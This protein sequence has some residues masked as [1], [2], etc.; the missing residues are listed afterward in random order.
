MN[1]RDLLKYTAASA[2]ASLAPATVRAATA[3]AGDITQYG[4]FELALPGPAEGNPFLDVTFGAT[5]TLQHRAVTV[6]GFYD[7]D[8]VYKVRF[9]PD[10]QGTWSYA[11]VSNA[12][13]LAGHT[14]SF[15]CAPPAPGTHGPVSVR[16]LQHFAHADGTQ[17]F[18]FGTTCYAWA[19]QPEEMQQQTLATLATAPFN[20]LRMCV[21]PKSYEFNH[22]EPPLYPFPRT[23]P[24]AAHPQGTNDLT[25]FNPAYFAHL[26]RLLAALR[27]RNIQA[28]IILF[29]P[30][31]RWGYATMPAEADDRYLRYVIARF[32][33][34]DNV[35][36]SLANEY[37]FMR[38]KTTQDFERLLRITQ[39]ED[40]YQHLRSIH[41]GHVMFNYGSSLVT[42][43]SL[44]VTDFASA[45]GW[46]QQWR[47][48]VIYDEC[49][50]EGH[51]PRR[52]G[53][54]SAQEMTR[55]FWLGV[56]A[57]CYVTHGETY[58]DPDLP[59]DEAGT[60]R[61]W[62][63]NGG[64]LRGQSPARIAF[65][66]SL[67]ES[68]A[69]HGLIGTP[70][71]YY[72]TAT[73]LAASGTD[74]KAPPA[75]ILHFFDEHQPIVHTFTLPAGAIYRAELIDPWE[76]TITPIPGQH[77]GKATL[78]LPARP[79]QALRFTQIKA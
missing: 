24:D 5:F 30:Y 58:F 47:K 35:W 59:F 57:G 16:G 73:A 39:Q 12:A 31:D 20:K 11:T 55:R 76:R 19:H 46:V 49:Q 44:Q 43:A 10:T 78:T 33:A 17:F 32:A 18:P 64:V 38:A 62:W 67:L 14:G 71:A 6:N 3:P 65:L 68:T 75:A 9:M 1:R 50:Y 63:A 54:I 74:P 21:F 26:E 28:D 77:T 40:P 25:R 60:Q 66:R 51:I 72:L 70:D 2:A 37:D 45:I 48:P 36:W 42:H 34:F 7:G 69:P 29:H 56:I 61:I 13:P 79:Y 52:W 41:H 15:R 27:E 8:G 53:N 4:I 23:A 22:N